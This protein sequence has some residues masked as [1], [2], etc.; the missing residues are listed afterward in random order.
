MRY[1]H[2]CIKTASFTLALQFGYRGGYT[3]IDV[4]E[5]IARFLMSRQA[6]LIRALAATHC[7]RRLES[8]QGRARFGVS[9]W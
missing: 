1:Y 6:P 7:R 9:W 5:D 3:F 2:W 4:A 8:I